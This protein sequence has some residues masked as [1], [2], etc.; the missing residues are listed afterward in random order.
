MGQF[1]ETKGKK[2]VLRRT[3]TVLKIQWRH[4]HKTQKYVKSM[5]KIV[6]VKDQPESKVKKNNW[7]K[8]KTKAL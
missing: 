5:I 3:E 6:Y 1:P 2:Q 8:G 7:E 4:H